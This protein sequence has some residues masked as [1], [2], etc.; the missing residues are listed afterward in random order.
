[1]VP[2]L[3]EAQRDRN[4]R[5]AGDCLGPEQAE[6]A[7][8]GDRRGDQDGEHAHRCPPSRGPGWRG[9]RSR[10]P[11]RRWAARPAGRF[12]VRPSPESSAPSASIRERRW[13]Q[14]S[15]RGVCRPFMTERRIR[16]V[17][18]ALRRPRITAA[19]TAERAERC[20]Q[21][22][23]TVPRVLDGN[24]QDQLEEAARAGRRRRAAGLSTPAA[25][26]SR[27]CT[28][29]LRAAVALPRACGTVRDVEHPGAGDHH[30]AVTGEPVAPAE[31]DVVAASRQCRVEAAG[32]PPR[33]RGGPACRRS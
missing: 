5:A 3:G 16:R 11:S 24:A 1:M 22:R 23:E 31:V 13:A 18:A 21:L 8:Q 27:R 15:R 7:D 20:Q 9:R 30:H 29:A 17:R 4:Q 32:G 10:R 2:D 19:G 26:L 25:C 14:T 6:Q 33:R 28:C 12:P